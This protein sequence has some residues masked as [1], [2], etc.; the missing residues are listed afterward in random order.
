MYCRNCGREID[1]KAVI[2]VHCGVPTHN[3]YLAGNGMMPQEQPKSA[4][5]FGIAGF[6]V[7]LLS[8][9]FGILFVI[10]PIAGL[11][12]SIVG[13]VRAK[14]HRLNGLAIAGLVLGIISTLIWSLWWLIFLTIGFN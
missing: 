13:M 5:G 3:M 12:L 2:C 4:N 7:S 6:V 8:L 14:N 10:V 11:S 9:W 1:D